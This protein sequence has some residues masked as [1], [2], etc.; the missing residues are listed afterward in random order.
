MKKHIVEMHCKYSD[1]LTISTFSM[2]II[3]LPSYSIDFAPFLGL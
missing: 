3:V 2:P 1:Y